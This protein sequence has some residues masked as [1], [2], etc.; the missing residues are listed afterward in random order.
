MSQVFEFANSVYL[1]R[2]GEEF[3]SFASTDFLG[4][5]ADKK[6]KKILQSALETESSILTG[7]VSSGGL[8]RV[9]TRVEARIS[10]FRACERSLIFSSLLHAYNSLLNTYSKPTG[11][12]FF[13]TSFSE[14]LKH[15]FVSLEME[16]LEFEPSSPDSLAELFSKNP[17]LKG[18]PVLVESLSFQK[19]EIAPLR[20]LFKV[21]QKNSAKMI[22][23]E[24]MAVGVLGILGSGG[25]EMA[26]LMGGEVLTLTS[27]QHALGFLGASVSGSKEEIEKILSTDASY[28]NQPL[29]PAYQLYGLEK[30]V[31]LIEIE[32]RKR[33]LLRRNALELRDGL[34]GMGYQFEG[35]SYSPIV[36]L[37]LGSS[38][39][40]EDLRAGLFERK[41]VVA[42]GSK[43]G[44]R[45]VVN[46]SHDL[47]HISEFLQ[48]AEDVGKRIGALG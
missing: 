47:K 13:S 32:V 5:A 29:M 27:F 38:S 26:G 34:R 12:V 22:V 35:D 46:A 40:N 28:I 20:E 7:S 8:R 19:G 9:H 45:I 21:C 39:L 17:E 37:D 18:A 15:H 24:S 30:A 41:F 31:G 16:L 6:I 44:A 4:I 25:V 11:A 23:D 3:V 14:E 33:S 10:K 2:A 42:V 43:Q 36:R 48:A 1:H